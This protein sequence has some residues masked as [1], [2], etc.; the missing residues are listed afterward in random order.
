VSF[1]AETAD[2]RSRL[3]L[4]DRA[5]LILSVALGAFQAWIGRYS[6]GPDGMSYLDIGDAYF[7]ADWKAAINGY[8]SPLYSI[9]LG[10]G[11][12][13]LR[14]SM[15]WEFPVVHLVNFVVFLGALLCFRI[16]LRSAAPWIWDNS[17][18]ATEDVTPLPAE[19]VVGWS[20]LLFLC[21]S[22][23][24]DDL[25]LVTPDLMVEALILLLGA[26]LLDLR[27][28]HSL[29]K[30]AAFGTVCGLGYLAKGVMFP[31]TFVFLAVLLFSGK[32]SRARV[33]GVLVAA[34]VFLIVSSPFIFALSKA[35]GRL[36]YGDTGK[37]AY[38]EMV[39]PKP[40]TTH[41]QG[42]PAG[43]GTPLH[44]TRKILDDPAV[45]EYAEP[46]SGTYPPWYDPSYWNEGMQWQFRLRSQVRVVV[47][48]AKAYVGI[49]QRYAA[50]ITGI[51]IFVLLGGRSARKGIAQNWPLLI[52]AS[53]GA[54]IYSLV[55]VLTRYT[56]GFVFLFFAAMIAGIRLPK[57]EGLEAPSR[58]IGRGVI[59]A[60]LLSL[61][62]LMA[63]PAYRTMTVAAGPA[64]GEQLPVA[65][66][67]Q[68]IG[69]RA[70]DRVAVF[71]DGVQDYWAHLGKFKIIA[72]IDSPNLYGREFWALP[73]NL[74]MKAYES[75]GRTQARAIIAWN[76]PASDI[77]QG[78]KQIG[79][80][81][82][83]V[84]VLH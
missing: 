10:A 83:Y 66:G 62:A 7:R 50:L 24:L 61:A 21:C 78:W 23:V 30:F 20:Y 5:F 60:M 64:L 18:A 43:S 40:P 57:N 68:K 26:L 32:I 63:D 69:L 2:A 36:T 80:T 41:W 77:S 48:S 44:A 12:H 55:L 58:S 8:W 73:A 34:I 54:G 14:P 82:Y 75:V 33:G 67:L 11:L 13:V 29:W 45:F 38:A 47:E 39:S 81:Q 37:L 74:K 15:R 35:K 72:E 49:L 70:N 3:V 4:I 56:A 16:F 65:E 53:A 22:L 59:L 17:R 28:R 6:M 19:I 25:M 71:G 31:L 76:P 1:V 52:V 84:Y 79:S 51:A 27:V 46:V 42:E 9:V